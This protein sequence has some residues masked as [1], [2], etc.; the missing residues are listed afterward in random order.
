MKNN[1]QYNF[2]LLSELSNICLEWYQ[3]NS[4]HG[5]YLNHLVH[6]VSS[7]DKQFYAQEDHIDYDGGFSSYPYTRKHEVIDD[8]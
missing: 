2:S 1:K 5:G 6:T 3:T 8:L 4:K 7:I